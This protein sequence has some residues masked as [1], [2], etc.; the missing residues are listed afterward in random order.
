MSKSIDDTI[1]IGVVLPAYNESTVIGEVLDG[2]PKSVTI[3]GKTYSIVV[4]VVD[5]GSEDLTAEVVEVKNDVELIRHIVNSGAGA[6]TRTGLHYARSI[7]C[8]Y[9][10]TMDSDGQH[11]VKDVLKLIGA[12]VANKADFI[13]GSR[14]KNKSG[15]MPFHKKIGNAGLGAITYLLL[16][17]YASDTQSGL[18]AFNR[19]ALERLEYH[20]NSYAFCSEMIWK[21]HQAKLKIEEIPI[22][23]IYTNYSLSRGQ[24]NITGAMNIITQLLKRRFLDILNG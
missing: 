15:N 10:I 24:K 4:I 9:A 20:S 6:A 2:I 13:I 16:G 14:L 5:D 21:A 7:G 1:M 19:K 12:I 8:Q 18:K 17:V 23:A 22:T 3:K 11:A